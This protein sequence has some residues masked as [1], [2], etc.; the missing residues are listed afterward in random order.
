MKVGILTFHRS[1]NYGAV[2]Q[3]FALQKVLKKKGFEAYI[4]DRYLGYKT[5][6]HRVYHL[7]YPKFIYTRL[8]WKIFDRFSKKYIQPRTKKYN[9]ARSLKQFNKTEKFDAVIVGSDQVWR[10]E[11][12]QIGNNY[13]LDFIND[14]AV[15][16]ISYAASF[17]NDKWNGDK[18]VTKN[19]CELL[20]DFNSISVREISGVKICADVFNLRATHVLDPTLLL[21]RED[22]ESIIDISSDKYRN[23]KLVSYILGN[24][25]EELRYCDN[26]ARKNKLDYEDIYH[27][28]SLYEFFSKP[29]YGR[30]KFIHLSVPQWLSEIK[31]AEY[32]ITNSFH[33]TVFAIIFGKQFIVLDHKS[34]GTSRLISLLNLTG[35]QDRFIHNIKDVS[36]EHLQKPIDYKSAHSMIEIEKKRSFEFIEHSLMH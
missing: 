7:F 33:A 16:K 28:Y 10:M 2:L 9:S 34:G 14:H 30:K 36:L 11:F 24:K 4:I 18:M 21:N 32:I 31:D 22:Y 6:F 25:L 26:F 20:K 13:F 8:T 3:A 19:I 29:I 15:K 35:L 27:A 5:L 1:K 23:K 12:S 17:G